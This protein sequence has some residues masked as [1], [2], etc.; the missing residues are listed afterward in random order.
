MNVLL[1]VCV[2]LHQQVPR[3][4]PSQGQSQ[5]T[6]PRNHDN[7]ASSDGTV[8]SIQYSTK[9]SFTIIIL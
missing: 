4:P 6:G 9:L 7:Q 3:V 1:C 8:Q 5:E 2:G